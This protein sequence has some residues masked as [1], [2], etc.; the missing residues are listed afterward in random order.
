MKTISFR[1]RP[2]KKLNF[3]LTKSRQFPECWEEVT[4]KQFKA[5]ESL[6]FGE[7]DDIKFISIFFD[8]PKRVAQ[9]CTDFL[10]YSLLE[11][12]EF[13]KDQKQMRD[14]LSVRQYKTKLDINS[15]KSPLDI[16]VE[17][18]LSQKEI[19]EAFK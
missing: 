17:Y 19:L 9:K 16:M 18:E 1:Y 15:I 6:H 7:I 2:I 14:F 5:F 8:L 10:K 3:Y 13:L 11:V 12:L 4:E